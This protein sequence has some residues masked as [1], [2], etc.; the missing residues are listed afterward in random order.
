MSGEHDSLGLLTALDGFGDRFS[1]AGGRVMPG[2]LNW[3]NTR[4]ARVE[5]RHVSGYLV[6][7]LSG[8]I[9]SLTAPVLAG[10]FTKAHDRHRPPYGMI[11]DLSR[12]D[13]RDVAGLAA[14]M[15]AYWRDTSLDRSLRLV[16]ADHS[17]R[18]AL[19][20]ARLDFLAPVYPTLQAAVDAGPDAE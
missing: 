8:L 17:A 6:V 12:A 4:T 16:A 5:A 10:Q 14:L 20:S 15:M 2:S 3:I 7:C 19:L 9:S 11:V 18:E 1:C 13:L